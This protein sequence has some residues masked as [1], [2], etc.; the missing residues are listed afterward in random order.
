MTLLSICSNALNGIG[1]F[2]VPTSFYA[3]SDPTAVLAVRLSNESGQ[4]LEKEI[5]WQ[6]LITEYTFSTTSGTATYA[7]PGD[8][9][10]FANMSQ[11]DR[12][13]MWRMTGPIPSPVYQWLKS[14]ISV[15]STMNKYFM[16]RASYV[17]IYPTPTATETIAYDYYSM[18]WMRIQVSGANSTEWTADLDTPRLS[19]Q[20]ME[21]DLRWRFLQ[22]KAMPFETEYLRYEKI[23]SLLADDNGGRG[24]INLGRMPYSRYGNLPDT[25]Y[26]A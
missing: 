22:A 7:L 9:R 4:D 12:T 8:F 3:S 13:N 25:G 6:E 24:V 14:G 2:A 21:A 18:S 26:G 15:A 19:G 5:R 1:G 17:T 16:V 20:L 23:K 10:A 11:W